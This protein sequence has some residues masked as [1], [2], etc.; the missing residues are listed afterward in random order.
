[1]SR[2]FG[3]SWTQQ[4]CPRVYLTCALMRRPGARVALGTAA[5]NG[6]E[7]VVGMLLDAGADPLAVDD[8]QR[9]AIVWAIHWAQYKTARL[10]I[11]RGGIPKKSGEYKKSRLIDMCKKFLSKKNQ[12]G[13][14]SEEAKAGFLLAPRTPAD[15]EKGW[16]KIFRMLEES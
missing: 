13:V 9:P 12:A 16:R 6:H 7:A 15:F 10:L 5:I 2:C 1:M 11:A 3:A 8:R 4:S 14:R